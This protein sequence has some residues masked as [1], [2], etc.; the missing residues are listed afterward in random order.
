MTVQNKAEILLQE[1]LHALAPMVRGLIREGVTYPQF[2][3][4]IKATFFEAARQELAQQ[5]QKQTDSAISVRSGVHRKDVRVLG[6]TE[7]ALPHALSLASQV[8]TR[9]LASPETT[10]AAGAPAP[11]ARTGPMP[12][13][14]ALAMAVSKDVH[15]R[16]VLEEL[17][18]L[19]LVRVEGEHVLPEKTSF[20]PSEGYADMAAFMALNLGDHAAAAMGNLAGQSPPFLEQSVFA[21]GLSAESI[22]LLALLARQGWKRLF[23]DTVALATQRIER[24]APVAVN[25]RMR[26]GVYFYSETVPG[27]VPSAASVTT[28]TP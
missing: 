1:T 8:Y 18:R 27:P 17:L 3:Q 11:L 20:I 12:S 15:P 22:E 10:D 4:A 13:F 28:K 26:V 21:D 23:D 2:A 6:Q 5:G 25:H 19:K 24:D 14:E 16:T 7:R 9:W